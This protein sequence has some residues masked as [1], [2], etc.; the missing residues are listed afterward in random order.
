MNLPLDRGTPR[1]WFAGDI[2]GRFSHI[3][4]QLEPMP[5]AERPVAIVFLGDL[6]PQRQ[7][8]QE[9]RP[10]HDAAIECWHIHGNHDT[11]RPDTWQNMVDAH[12]RNLHSRVVTIAG[13]R[14]AGLGGVFRGEVWSPQDGTEPPL[15][16]SYADYERDLRRQT[17]VRRRVAKMN[18]IQAESIPGHVSEL[19]NA[20]RDGRLRRHSSTIFPDTVATLARL[21]ADVL[22]SHEAPA[23]HPH[24]FRAIDNLARAMGVSAVF[25]GHHHSDRTYP[26]SGTGYSVHSVGLRGI[27]DLNGGAILLAEFG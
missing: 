23:A 12:E 14:I 18:A 9:Y 26:D 3:L 21:R 25:H 22:V 10:F 24:G 15:F 8:R 27:R 1:I 19:A 6:E 13:V 20:T 16:Q 2:H 17:G 5:L 7:L 4:K 11:D